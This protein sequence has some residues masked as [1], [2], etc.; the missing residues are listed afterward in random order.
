MKTLTRF[1]RIV[2]RK[3]VPNLGSFPLTQWISSELPTSAANLSPS[4]YAPYTAIYDNFTSAFSTS[5]GEC[6]SARRNDGVW[7]INSSMANQ[8]ITTK[9]VARNSSDSLLPKEVP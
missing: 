1:G 8:C 4:E 5:R 7:R 6:L 9:R 2:R 3:K